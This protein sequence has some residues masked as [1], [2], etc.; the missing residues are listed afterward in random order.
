M[1]V[2]GLL[3]YRASKLPAEQQAILRNEVLVARGSAK[4]PSVMHEVETATDAA[5]RD[6]LAKNPVSTA[7]LPVVRRQIL[8]QVKA[9]FQIV[10]P[11]HM[12]IDLGSVKGKIQGKPL[13][14]RTKFNS[15]DLTPDRTYA[16]VWQ[17]GVPGKSKLWRSETMSLA[18][19]TFHEFAI[20]ADLFDENGLLTVAFI[21]ENDLGL[22]FPLEDGFEVLYPTGGFTGNYIRGLG[23]ILC[24]MALLAT[25]GL[26]ASSFL[27]FPVAAFV[28]LAVLLITLSSGTMAGAIAEGTIAG[29]NAEKGIK[30][31]SPADHIVIPAF[32]AALAVINLAKDFSPIDSLSSGRSVSWTQLGRALVQIVGLLSGILAAGGIYVFTRRELATAQGN[33]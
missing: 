30:G 7:D 25:L 11:A 27:S 10:P 13:Q 18:H 33:S 15:P 17:I 26:A 8:E 31:S 23:I 21:N 9:E 2:Y 1:G 32:K 3:Q 28:S 19:E 20:P 12:K 4:E 22:L 24:W 14:I 29:Y 6:R 16:G 5:L